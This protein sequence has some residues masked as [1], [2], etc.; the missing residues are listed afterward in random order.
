MDNIS[1]SVVGL[2]TGEF[3][4]RS[5]KPEN[6]VEDHRTRR[7]LFLSSTWLASN[8]PDIDLVF[9]NLLPAPLGY[10]LHHRGHTHTFLYAF[11]QA[12]LIALLF[13][14]IWPNARR[15]IKNS[16][17]TRW[18]FILCIASG[19]ILHI[20]MDYLNSYG[21]HPFHP[22]DSHWF[23]GDMVFIVEPVFWV[24]FGVPIIMMLGSRWLK[25]LLI[26]ILTGG[27]VFFTFKGFLLWSS[28]LFLLL[29]VFSLSIFQIKN[30]NCGKMILA[31]AGIIGMAFIFVQNVTSHYSRR[32]VTETI[33]HLSPDSRVLD[34]A[35]TAFPSNPI[36]WSFVSIES[37][38][39][40]NLYRLRK[41]FLSLLPNVL[42]VN[43]CPSS[44][45]QHTPTDINTPIA[46]LPEE[47]K[48]NLQDFRKLAS[49]NC[50]F[51]TWLRFIRMPFIEESIAVDLRYSS[52]LRGNFTTINLQNFDG[53][54]CFDNTPQWEM[55]RKDLLK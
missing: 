33:N 17:T 9:T 22:Y 32:E 11:P 27:L 20:M 23:Y 21:V 40:Q 53:T 35:M 10:L 3:I 14:L 7:R 50:T 46:F 1:H 38:E 6:N 15:L 25:A 44:F 51:S 8:F 12:L 43:Q 31:I 39:Q 19:F 54:K 2:A 30:A 18:G 16:V 41:G 5:F 42:P 37:I 45:T 47:Y 26:A 55:P 13:W 28:L 29:L 52:S 34:V 49:T 48:G 36:C 4:H 24:A